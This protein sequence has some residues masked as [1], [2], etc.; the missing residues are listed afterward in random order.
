MSENT[1]QIAVTSRVRLARNY[2]DLPF[3]NLNNPANAQLCIDRAKQALESKPQ[4]DQFSLYLLREM[5]KMDQ[6]SLME[7]H[8]ISRDLLQHSNVGAALVRGDSHISVMVNEEDHL[9]IQAMLDGFALSDAASLAFD[10]EDKLASVCDFSFDSQLGYLT[11]CPT[12]TGT[13]MR[14]S[15]MLH[16]PMLVMMQQIKAASNE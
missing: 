11:A 8:L 16:L 13:G 15:L 14:A 9:R 10:A 6:L 7:S 2:H 1:R 12:N 4:S 5:N 3:S